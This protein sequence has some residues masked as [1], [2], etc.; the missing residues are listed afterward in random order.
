MNVYTMQCET[1]IQSHDLATVYR[2]N[3]YR[4]ASALA[5]FERQRGYEAE[6]EGTWLLKQHG[7]TRKPAALVVSGLRQ[8]V[9]A[10]MIR[11]AKRL[12]GG[13]P[14][15]ATAKKPDAGTLGVTTAQP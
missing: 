13:S 9:G 7:I 6:A 8:I 14:T 11:A 4:V 12:V 3:Q 10:A 2:A 5:A 1:A 15:S